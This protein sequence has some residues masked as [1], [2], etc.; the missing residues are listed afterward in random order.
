MTE[1]IFFFVDSIVSFFLPRFFFFFFIF[2]LSHF[3]SSFKQEKFYDLTLLIFIN[4]YF[5]IYIKA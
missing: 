3:F 2:L 4:L 5:I 1:K